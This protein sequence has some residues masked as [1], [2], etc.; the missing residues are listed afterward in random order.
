MQAHEQYLS[1]HYKLEVPPSSIYL[2]LNHSYHCNVFPRTSS[3]GT[4]EGSVLE[5]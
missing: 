4:L 1:S 3:V 5:D 2:K